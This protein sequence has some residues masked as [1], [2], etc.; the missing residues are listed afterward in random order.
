MRPRS[1]FDNTAMN[2]AVVG[3][4][5]PSFWLGLILILVF[6]VK[7]R[8]LPSGGA[9]STWHLVLPAFTLS[10][11]PMARIARLVRAG[12]LEALAED[13]VV[14]ARSKGLSSTKVVL[15]HALRNAIRPAMTDAGMLLAQLV[16]GAV[17]TETVFSWPGLGRLV[18][19]AISNRDYPLVQA[20]VL[21]IGTIFIA[22]NL[23]VDYSYG[24]L[25]PRIREVGGPHS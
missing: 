10:L 7:L 2:V 13:Y 9:G 19:Q 12:M 23:V 25:D 1:L 6:S 16:G 15:K 17:L 5:I 20:G 4:A 11:I 21:V 14:T 24:L 3:Q 8:L 22:S 18:I